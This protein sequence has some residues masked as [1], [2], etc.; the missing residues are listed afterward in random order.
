MQTIDQNFKRQTIA[1]N[2]EEMVTEVLGSGLRQN[3]CPWTSGPA[4]AL[5]GSISIWLRRGAFY[6]SV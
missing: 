1:S 4:G 5:W 6:A 3:P 2:E